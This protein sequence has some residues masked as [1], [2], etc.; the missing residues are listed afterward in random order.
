MPLTHWSD[1]PR[2]ACWLLYVTNSSFTVC[3]NGNHQSY[4]RAYLMTDAGITDCLMGASKSL[5]T[6]SVPA[7]HHLR[8]L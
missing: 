2:V 1:K 5:P 7:L 8:V 4:V 3:P 6:Y